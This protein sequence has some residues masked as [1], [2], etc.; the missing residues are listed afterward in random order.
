[1]EKFKAEYKKVY[2]SYY[3][4]AT[5]QRISY[6][7]Y[8]AKIDALVEKFVNELMSSSKIEDLRK[9][10]F[11]NYGTMN[12]WGFETSMKFAIACKLHAIDVKLNPDL[13][14]HL[15]QRENWNCWHEDNCSC[16][17]C[18]SYDSSD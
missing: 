2:D 4:P 10:W 17:F 1:M 12:G 18:S 3:K 15:P 6:Y 7:D 13:H 5:A 9:T 16:G 8:K 14:K 11:I